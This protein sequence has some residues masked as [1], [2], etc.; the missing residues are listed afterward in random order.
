[1]Y[2]SGMMLQNH[3]YSQPM[4]GRHVH[5]PDRLMQVTY[6]QLFV[7]PLTYIVTLEGELCSVHIHI[8]FCITHL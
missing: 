7:Y 2:L 3:P 8:D 5:L 6:S 1:M 4:M